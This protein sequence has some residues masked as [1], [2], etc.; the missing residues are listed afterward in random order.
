MGAAGL[1]EEDSSV[2]I[3]TAN[4]LTKAA[5]HKHAHN[6]RKMRSTSACNDS[7]GKGTDDRDTEETC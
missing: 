3:Y 7:T 5:E 2:E 6:K 4:V 1:K